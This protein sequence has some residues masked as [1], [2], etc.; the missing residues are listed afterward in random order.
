LNDSLCYFDVD[1]YSYTNSFSKC[2]PITKLFFALSA[3]LISVSA[4]SPPVPIIIFSVVSVLLLVFAKVR[5]KLYF[6]LMISPILFVSASCIIIA[7]F[8]GSTD[9]IA[10]MKIQGH[11]ITVYGDAVNLS[12]T[13][14]CR[15]LGS[16]SSLFFLSLT[17][18]M[19]DTW[20]VLRK[21]GTPAILVEMS[22]LIYRYLFAF[23]EVASRIHT[24][25]ELRLG[26][27]TLRRTFTSISLLATNL[28]IGTLQQGER[29][30][31]AMTAR[32]YDGTIR[33]LN[34]TSRPAWSSLAGIAIFDILMV[35][36]ILLTRNMG[37][38]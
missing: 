15:V 33:M 38:V 9:P 26:Y 23:L 8:F 14:F 36:M 32:G 29:T 17:T 2:S 4:P 27:S 3:I 5:A 35:F 37:V 1:K 18:P 24:A 6:K 11:G 12:I 13:L 10:Y 34:E 30:F 28:F 7:F 21:M 16:V 19:M 22:M 31:N 25:Q 20:N